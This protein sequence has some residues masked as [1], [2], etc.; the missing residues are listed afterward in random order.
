MIAAVRYQ[1]PLLPTDASGLV[2][3]NGGYK[4]WPYKT[5]FLIDSTDGGRTWTA[6]RQLCTRF[7]QTRGYPAALGDGTVVVVHDTRYGP[8]GPGT[9]AM[10]SRD[11]GSSWQ[12]EVY[13]LDY[14]SAPGSYA[15]SV[16]LE[17]DVILT[18]TGSTRPG[19]GP[20]DPA[21]MTAIRW[22]PVAD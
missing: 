21:Q 17:D 9:R 5:V 2:E 18:V 11:E 13:Y 3:K 1:R 22:K 14:S 20:W 7:G 8:G 12:D 6:F 16:V 10:I 19:Q 15:A 4:G